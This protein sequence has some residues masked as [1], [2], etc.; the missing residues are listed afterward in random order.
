VLATELPSAFAPRSWRAH[1][2]PRP[3]DWRPPRRPSVGRSRPTC[4]KSSRSAVARRAFVT[5]SRSAR[6]RFSLRAQVGHPGPVWL[7]RVQS[8]ALANYGFGAE[9]RQALELRREVRGRSRG[10]ERL[11]RRRVRDSHRI[12]VLHGRMAARS[13]LARRAR[14]APES[15]RHARRWAQRW[16][17]GRRERNIDGKK[18]ATRRYVDSLHLRPRLDFLLPPRQGRHR[19]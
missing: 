17:I 4:W 6:S 10:P 12:T 9:V 5:D 14:A 11:Q 18:A 13:L 7:D 16:A 2:V 1:S 8:D 19:R 3:V 15:V